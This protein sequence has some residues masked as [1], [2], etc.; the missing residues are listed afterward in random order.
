MISRTVKLRSRLIVGVLTSCL[1]IL[2]GMSVVSPEAR[3]APPD[4][5]PSFTSPASATFT[6]GVSGPPFTVTADGE[7]APTFGVSGLL[8][9]GLTLSP[10]GVLS[11]TPTSGSDGVY[12]PTFIA[13]NAVVPDAVQAF[14]L[15]VL[16]AASA[17]VAP[18]ITSA[19]SAGADEGETGF[20]FEVTASGSPAPALT[21]TGALP[22]GVTFVDHGRGA[23]TIAGTPSAG[24]AASY[25]LTITAANGTAPDAV[26]NFTLTIGVPARPT[27]TGVSPTMG[28]EQ[29]GNDVVVTGTGLSSLNSVD[30]VLGDHTEYAGTIDSFLT[31]DTSIEVVVPSVP[32]GTG[33]V[34]VT[35]SNATQTSAV[36]RGDRYTFGTFFDS[37]PPDGVRG[38]AYGFAFA[39][40]AGP[41]VT[42][43]VS[44]GSLPAGLALGAHSGELSGMPT[45][46]G[47]ST[48][49]LTAFAN[50]EPVAISPAITLTVLA[51]AIG[52]THFLTPTQTSIT[53]RDGARYGVNFQA[54]GTPAPTYQVTSGRLP[55]GMTLGRDGLL[56][57]VAHATPAGPGTRGNGY[58]LIASDGGVFSF[59]DARF[60]GSTGGLRLVKPIVAMA[61]TASGNGYW[62]IAS[63]GGVFSF[64]DA[65]FHGST[66]GMNLVSPIVAT[67]RSP[68]GSPSSPQSAFPFTVTAANGASR[69]A[70]IRVTVTV[71]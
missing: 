58:W 37:N 49:G 48:F 45:A 40:N 39:T 31:T 28:P 54:D 8:P 47:T 60:H 43:A 61:A 34:D 20:S 16:P 9:D 1:L 24:T 4:S 3:A 63:D 25:P 53:V 42:Y 36:V 62:L 17:P 46:V 55:D 41:S 30:F 19:A 26:Q 69:T 27:V 33:T 64:G 38:V 71:R 56:Y 66:G 32:P 35:V 50:D 7:P 6:V 59:G 12:H 67:E 70:A 44:S 52:P 23:A 57:G 29:G 10:Q 11:G 14:E 68:F 22:A 13:T 21:A 65:R 15:T 51:T 5:P 18:A 2:G